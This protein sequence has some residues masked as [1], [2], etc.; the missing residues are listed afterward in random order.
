MKLS[1]VIP[2][3]AVLALALSG[4]RADA[5]A[6][7][8][9]VCVVSPTGGG[10]VNT[11]VFR[12]VPSL[13]RGGVATLQGFYF[14]PARKIAPLDGS[15]VMSS[16]GRIRLGVFVHSTAGSTNDFTLAGIVDANLVGTLSYDTDGDFVP[17]G[18][19]TTTLVDCDSIVV[20]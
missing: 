12:S 6:R 3:V 13:G 2:V 1:Q 18:T 9:D 15:A 5:A 17:N 16:D 11:F 8:R 4:A 10:S 20:P 19:L 7:T 14:S